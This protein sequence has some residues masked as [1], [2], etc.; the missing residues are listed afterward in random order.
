MTHFIVIGKAIF[1]KDVPF[2]VVLSHL[3]PMMLI[4]LAT[5]SAATWLFRRRVG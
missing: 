3:W 5:L 1:L 2:E 4:A